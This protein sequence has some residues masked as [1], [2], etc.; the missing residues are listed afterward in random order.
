VLLFLLASVV[1][2]NLGP[3]EFLV[4]LALAIPG[5]L[6]IGRAARRVLRPPSRSA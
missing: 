1:S 4:V 6:L 5:G 3:V 2:G